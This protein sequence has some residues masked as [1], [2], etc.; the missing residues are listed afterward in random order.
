MPGL[1]ICSP[2]TQIN[3][4]LIPF[5][6]FSSTWSQ[7]TKNLCMD[8]NIIVP[9]LIKADRDRPLD[10]L[11]CCRFVSDLT[12]VMRVCGP[13]WFNRKIPT[14]IQRISRYFLGQLLIP[15]CL[16][17]NMSECV[18]AALLQE[19]RAIPENQIWTLVQSTSS[20]WLLALSHGL[21]GGHTLY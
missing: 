12:E 4:E 9:Q 20:L 6:E 8:N 3:S 13:T 16:Q 5:T 18:Q 7:S 1:I 19:W 15:L 17:L 11:E 14:S 21:S 2:Q 10:M